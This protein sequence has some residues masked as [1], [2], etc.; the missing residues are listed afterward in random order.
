MAALGARPNGSKGNATTELSDQATSP[1]PPPHLAGELPPG[2]VRP[3]LGRVGRRRRAAAAAA[4]APSPRARAQGQA[5]R[6]ATAFSF[7]ALFFAGLA[8]SAGAGNGVR[9]L[10]DDGRRRQARRPRPPPAPRRTRPAR[11]RPAPR[12]TPAPTSAHADQVTELAEPRS[13]RRRADAADRAAV[14]TRGA[15]VGTLR[16]VAAGHGEAVGRAKRRGRPALASP[17]RSTRSCARGSQAEGAAARRRGKPAGRDGLAVP[18]RRPTRR[19]RPPASAC[20]SRA[21]WSQFSRQ[22]HVDWALVLA[23]LRT[24]GHNGRVPASR[25]TLDGAGAPARARSAAAPTAGRPRSSYSSDTAFADRAVALRH[26]YRAV[27]LA[28]LVYG[29][30]SQKRDLEDRVLHDDRIQIYSGGR[31]DVATHKVDVR[32][33]AADALPRRDLPRGH[34]LVPDQRAPPVRPAGRRLGAHL[35]PRG[36]HRRA[37]RRVHLRAPAAGRRDRA[38]RPQPS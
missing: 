29:L 6:F 12:A 5:R 8:L 23:V 19:L 20:A 33:L 16:A 9:A 14:A 30:R 26:Y 13:G 3:G 34:G 17:R 2:R 24:E 38:G 21:S 28:S 18:G 35:R 27:G 22:A 37:R 36:R 1:P 32:V 7:C 11:R 4:P 10:L 31:H 15:S 25:A